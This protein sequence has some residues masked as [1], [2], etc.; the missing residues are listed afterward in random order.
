MA[1]AFRE[2]LTNPSVTEEYGRNGAKWVKENFTVEKMCAKTLD[3]YRSL[4][5]S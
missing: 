3:L 4:S 2:A 5:S 1:R